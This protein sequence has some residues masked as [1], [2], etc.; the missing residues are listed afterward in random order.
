MRRATGRALFVVAAL[1]VTG[2]TAGQPAAAQ[3]ELVAHFVVLAKKGAPLARTEASVR[4]AGGQVLQR[5]P[6][7]GVV[8]ATSPNAGFAAA[9]RP[10][11]G[12][13][14]AGATRDLF[15]LE[16]ARPHRKP[17]NTLSIVDNPVAA[18]GAAEPL[19]AY[20]WNMRQI[21]ADR[22]NNVSGGSRHVVVG[23]LDTGFDAS[24]PDLAPNVDESRSVGCGGEGVPDTSPEAWGPGPSVFPH[25]IAVAGLIA[26]ARN[27][28]GIA[29]VAPNVRIA[30]VRVSD[31]GFIYPENLICGYVWAAD[32]GIQVT[33]A[34]FTVDPW[35]RWCGDDPDQAAAIAAMRRAMDYA[36]SRGVV[37]VAAIGNANWDLSHPVLDTYSPLHDP[38]DRLT[39]DNCYQ[40]PAEMPGVVAVSGVGA[41]ERKARSSNYGIRDV[42]VAAPSG[43]LHQIPDTPDSNP[44]VLTTMNNGQWGYFG[45]TSAA[46]PHAAGVVALIR[47]AHP[48]W[49]PRQVIAALT[50]QADRLPCPPGGVF[51]PDGTGAWLAHCEGGRSGKGFYGHGLI[52]ALDAVTR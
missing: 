42:D 7:I 20:Q 12:V 23:V 22:A 37:N 51:D 44:G 1:V 6:Q 43:D 35:V 21:R 28:V 3:Q 17:T 31:E 30:S 26:A 33:N 32:H 11:P 46:A 50:R 27:G 5:W 19:A 29:G 40:V 2:L 16:G 45:G 10:L 52:D 39:G 36:T 18:T 9:V 47:G 34:S 13:V 4:A 8:V 24:H 49:S 15:E 14:A 25:G 48:G 38:V 41:Q